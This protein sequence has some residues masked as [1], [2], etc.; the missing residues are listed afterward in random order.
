[1]SLDIK[2]QVKI[3]NGTVSLPNGPGLG[4]TPK[5]DFIDKFRIDS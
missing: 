5:R 2:K 3:N 4:V 1:V